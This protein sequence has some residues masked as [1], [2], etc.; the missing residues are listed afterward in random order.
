MFLGR[1]MKTS[2]VFAA[3][4]IA[5]FLHIGC[6]NNNANTDRTG[7]T[8]TTIQYKTI[9]GVDPN[10]L[11]LDIYHFG[12]RTPSKPVVIYVHGG[13]FAVGDKA[14]GINNKVTLFA[15]L[16]YIFVSVN[17]RLSPSQPS[18][19]TNRIMYPAHNDDVA[20]A[21]KWVYD[22]IANY[23]GNSAKIALMGHSAGAHLVCL[24]G[25]SNVFL[26]SRSISLHALK[27]IASIDTEGYDVVKQCSE[28]NE[29][30]INAFGANSRI[31]AEASPLYNIRRGTLYPKF[32]VAKR[33]T[34]S[35]IALADAFIAALESAGGIVSHIT[36]NQYDHEGI[37]D[38]IGAKDE[39]SVTEPLKAFFAQCFQ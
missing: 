3:I 27:G 5:V 6:S 22:N 15:S 28:N 36:A 32:F 2:L 39:T 29:L 19:D 4:F 16:D 11:S 7:S 35:R 17:Y 23:G 12:Q 37:N 20:D 10:L 1:T 9:R 34:I 26:P 25:T 18:R 24:T 30:Y 38:A 14:N 8:K 21:V 13:G 31:W 33:G